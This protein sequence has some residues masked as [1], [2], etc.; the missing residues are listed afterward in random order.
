MPIAESKVFNTFD[1]LT[2][3]ALKDVYFQ[4]MYNLC[5]DIKRSWLAQRIR[6]SQKGVK[7]LKVKL[8]YLLRYG[9]SLRPMA[10]HGYTPTGSPMSGA[11]GE[12]ELGIH[13]GSV[14]VSLKEIYATDGDHSMIGDIMEREMTGLM[15]CWP[16]YMKTIFWT[17]TSGVMGVVASNS[18]STTVTIDNTG[19]WNTLTK[20][21]CKL[22][23]PGMWISFRS[24]AGVSRGDPRRVVSVDYTAGTF[25]IDSAITIYDG[26]IITITDVQGLEDG[27]NNESSPGLYDAI[28]DS[29]TFQG[30]DRS[31]ATYA[32]LRAV[33]HDNSGTPRAPTRDL[34][35]NFFHACYEPDEAITHFDQL[36]NL[37]K[38]LVIT[39]DSRRFVNV[40][41]YKDSFNS[42]QVGRTRI[43][44]DDDH[45]RD[46]ITVVD[47]SQVFMV[48]KGEVS[49]LFGRGWYPLETRP[50]MCRNVAWC[51]LLAAQDVRKCGVLKDLTCAFP[52]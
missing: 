19:L 48:D 49:D 22:F 18:S 30:I 13:A 35:V 39:P 16:Y 9:W 31:S 40:Q 7:G 38:I 29:N 41:D 27:Y 17:P 11:T 34:L 8:P 12:F 33:V 50:F 28:D 32:R 26:D 52:S 44:E 3:Y 14:I 10:E 15:E 23:I 5:F 21:R 37:F 25:T 2:T 51:G 36:E 43:I 6:R 42:I 47:W 20:D 1:T 45:D 46:K 24:S 4:A